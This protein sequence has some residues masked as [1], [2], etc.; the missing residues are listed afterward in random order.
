MNLSYFPWPPRAAAA[1]NRQFISFSEFKMVTTKFVKKWFHKGWKHVFF[2]ENQPHLLTS[3]IILFD[4][5]MKPVRG[6]LK[7]PCQT[8]KMER[9]AKIVND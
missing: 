2:F 4:Q 8:S 6:V 5:Y 1:L 9:F 7:I 3:K